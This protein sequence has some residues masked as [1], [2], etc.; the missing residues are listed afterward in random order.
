MFVKPLDLAP[1]PPERPVSRME[2]VEGQTTVVPRRGVVLACRRCVL[3]VEEQLR[4]LG[5]A[6]VLEDG[7]SRAGRV[8]AW[9]DGGDVVR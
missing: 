4:Q 8:A 1:V 5:A 9:L 3:E 7:R 2:P 6:E